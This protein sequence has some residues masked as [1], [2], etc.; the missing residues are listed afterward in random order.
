M[1]IAQKKKSEGKKIENTNTSDVFLFIF[2]FLCRKEKEK[3]PV[4]HSAQ[5]NPT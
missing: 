4:F 1:L 5:G 3:P 2:S